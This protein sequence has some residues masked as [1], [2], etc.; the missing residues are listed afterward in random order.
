VSIYRKYLI[1][2]GDTIQ[3][4]AFIMLND[5]DR[6]ED[7]VTLNDLEYPYIV[8]TNAER[9]EN[10]EHLRTLG[11]EVLIPNDGATL[12]EIEKRNLTLSNKGRI[13]NNYYDMTMGMDMYLDVSKG[14]RREFIGQ[15]VGNNR[16]VATVTGIN[17]LR[18]S[19]VLRLLTRYGT[20]Y[21][22]PNYG[23]RIPNYIGKPIESNTLQDITTEAKRTI[24]TDE[25][26]KTVKIA[27]AVADRDTIYMEFYITPLNEDEAFTLFLYRA[28][29]GDI[30]IE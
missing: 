14:D 24:T 17:N 8:Q 3:N 6:W 12:E 10:P 16:D 29:D 30:H 25:R 21:R 7:I 23:S 2:Q 26:V 20:L 22:H 5:I 28:E 27:Q 19:L 18:Q 4:I 15:L 11:D 9:M 13:A 1:K